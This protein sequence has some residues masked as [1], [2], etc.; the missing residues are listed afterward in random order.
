MNFPKRQ[1]FQAIEKPLV[2]VGS[3]NPIKIACTDTAFSEAFSQGFIV[4]GINSASQV[5]EQPI[6]DEETYLGAKNRVFNSRNAFPEADYWVGIEGGIEEDAHGMYAFA[7]IYIENKFGLSGKSKTG[8]F[9]LP[10]AIKKLIHSGMELGAADDQLFA[11]ENS[12]QQGGSVGILTHGAVSR[13]N[14]YNQAIIL[15]LIPFL[16]KELY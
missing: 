15:A 3:K 8:T 1:N 9:Y 6:G 11:Q 14:Y 5:S 16:N 12:K 13:Q 4:D 7:W 10:D 2:I